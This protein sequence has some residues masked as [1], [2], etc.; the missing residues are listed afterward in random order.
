MPLNTAGE[1]PSAA[2]FRHTRQAFIEDLIEHGGDAHVLVENAAKQ[3]REHCDKRD[4]VLT[5]G[6]WKVV[7]EKVKEKTKA[8]AKV[9]RF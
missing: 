8:W 7:T 5:L 2:Y 3:G 6:K 9:P 4:M 1:Q